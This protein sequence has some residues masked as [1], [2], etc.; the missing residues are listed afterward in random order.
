VV[1][2][3]VCRRS[4]LRHQ[5]LAMGSSF[6]I[7]GRRH[8][9]TTSTRFGGSVET[10]TTRK[11][12]HQPTHSYFLNPSD[13]YIPG[14]LFQIYLFQMAIQSRKEIGNLFA[15]NVIND[16]SIRAFFFSLSWRKTIIYLNFA[17]FAKYS[18]G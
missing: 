1:G 6:S 11:D 3:L 18:F 17:I 8:R 9:R 2:I 5:P 16:S 7:C 14:F 12:K 13:H 10:P 4:G 15:I